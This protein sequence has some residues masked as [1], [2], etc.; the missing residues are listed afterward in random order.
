MAKKLYVF[1]LPANGGP[2]HLVLRPF[3]SSKMI[4][5]DT[6]RYKTFFLMGKDGGLSVKQIS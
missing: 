5:T 1:E 2:M 6:D 4:L 3:P